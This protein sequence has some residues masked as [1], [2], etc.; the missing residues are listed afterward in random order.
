MSGDGPITEQ[1]DAKQYKEDNKP[2]FKSRYRQ[3]K[4]QIPRSG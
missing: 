4:Q 2:T 3:I 1:K